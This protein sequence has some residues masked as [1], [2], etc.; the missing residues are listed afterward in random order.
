MKKNSEIFFKYKH[1]AT[2]NIGCNFY[3]YLIIMGLNYTL[4]IKMG[5][6]YDGGGDPYIT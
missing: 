6:T 4:G 2:Q 1:T 3:I 5:K